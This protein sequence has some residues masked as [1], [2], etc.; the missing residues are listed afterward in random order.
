[1][2]GL[3]VDLD[4]P[5]GSVKPVEVISPG[6]DNGKDKDNGQVIAG[7]GSLKV[8]GDTRPLKIQSFLPRPETTNRTRLQALIRHAALCLRWLWT[9]DLCITIYKIA[10][11][12]PSHASSP[13]ATFNSDGSGLAHTLASLFS[14]NAVS[15]FANEHTI[16]VLP[17]TPWS[18]VVSRYVVEP[19]I[20]MFVGLSVF[21]GLTA[22]YHAFACLAL[23][24]GWE[25]ESWE[26]DLMDK[27]WTGTS[28]LDIWGRRWH[29]L[30]RVSVS[31]T[32][33]IFLYLLFAITTYQ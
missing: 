30:F 9:V 7:D 19:C 22:G 23:I 1:M 31:P 33:L 26:I 28:L 14:D 6:R 18:F 25:V 15:R 11:S 4:S 24:L 16:L 3:E 20:V 5:V 27:P 32:L 2:I 8:D 10:R 12:G 29:Q 17:H 13:H 21:G